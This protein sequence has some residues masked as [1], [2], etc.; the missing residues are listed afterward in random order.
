[1]SKLATSDSD[2]ASRKKQHQKSQSIHRA[3]EEVYRMAERHSPECTLRNSLDS[4]MVYQLVVVLTAFGLRLDRSRVSR[5]LE[6]LHRS[7]QIRLMRRWDPSSWL[8][9]LRADM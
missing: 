8:A 7:P 6:G 4:Q 9:M 2:H 3:S 5:C 1:M